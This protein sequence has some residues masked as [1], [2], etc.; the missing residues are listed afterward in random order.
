MCRGESRNFRRRGSSPCPF[1]HTVCVCSACWEYKTL[2][3]VNIVYWLQCRHMPTCIMQSK[4]TKNKTNVFVWEFGIPT[5][6]GV[7]VNPLAWSVECW[8]MCQG[9]RLKPLRRRK[10]DSYIKGTKNKKKSN[11]GV[12]RKFGGSRIRLWKLKKSHWSRFVH[13][14]CVDIPLG[15]EVYIWRSIHN[16]N[17]KT[18]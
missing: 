8:I 16:T 6:S 9:P 5:S 3:T 11:R 18:Q 1:T 7:C 10:N 4:F 14:A 12:W 13:I 17:C 15:F 2:D